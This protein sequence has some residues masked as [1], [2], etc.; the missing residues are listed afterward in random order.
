[1]T[2]TAPTSRRKFRPKAEVLSLIVALY[3]LFYEV[4]AARYTLEVDA[5]ASE[6][7]SIENMLSADR[8]DLVL[9]GF[10]P[11]QTKKV[12]RSAPSIF[13]PIG[14]LFYEEEPP[15]KRRLHDELE[16]ALKQHS[17]GQ[18]L[19]ERGPEATGAD[20]RDADLSHIVLRYAN[21]S[22]SC[23]RKVDLHSSDLSQSTLG[24]VALTEAD[25]TG[26]Q[27]ID[28]RLYESN[29]AHA[30][31]ANVNFSGGFLDNASF[32]SADLSRA[33]FANASLQCVDLSGADLNAINGWRSIA[34]LKDANIHGVQNAPAGFEDFAKQK[35]AVDR[36]ASD[37]N[38]YRQDHCSTPAVVKE[39]NRPCAPE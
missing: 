17:Y 15:F 5:A 11:A 31:A 29:L 21:L 32:N 10:G 14:W 39:V 36:D 28:A 38:K 1:M 13:W 33:T 26:A 20:L 37:W 22:Y 8:L 24:G 30:K 25:L 19:G 4:N 12:R 6:R 34:T 35:L 18:E 2:D 27:F 3:A 23:M 7:A 9:R 16:S